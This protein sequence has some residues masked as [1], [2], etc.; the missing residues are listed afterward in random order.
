VFGWVGSL[1][2]NDDIVTGINSNKTIAT[3]SRSTDQSPF[4]DKP[5]QN[6]NAGNKPQ[7][8]NINKR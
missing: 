5:R 1:N 8:N 6:T 4:I 7:A 2:E 3:A